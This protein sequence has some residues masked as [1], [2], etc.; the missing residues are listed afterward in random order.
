VHDLQGLVRA[1]LVTEPAVAAS[2]RH[3][4]ERARAG[5]TVLQWLGSNAATG[6]VVNPRDA[7]LQAVLAAAQRWLLA[8]PQPAA[9]TV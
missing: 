3:R 6:F 8:A 5:A 9:A 1:C 2:V 7:A 4:I